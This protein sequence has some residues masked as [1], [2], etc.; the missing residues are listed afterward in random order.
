MVVLILVFLFP[1]FDYLLWGSLSFFFSPSY[2]VPCTTKRSLV[3]MLNRQRVYTYGGVWHMGMAIG[4]VLV[5]F[6]V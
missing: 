3:I 4:G 5:F 1:Q 6:I 2:G